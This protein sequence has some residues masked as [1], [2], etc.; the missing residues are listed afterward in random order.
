MLRN[1]YLRVIV[2]SALLVAALATAGA[3]HT[4]SN[5]DTLSATDLNSNFTHIH[6]SMVGG[7]GARL[8][9]A[10]VSTSANIAYTKLQNGRGIARAFGRVAGTCA[11]G[12][13]TMDNQLNLTSI[14]HTGT[15]VYT[16]TMNY[17]ATNSSFTALGNTENSTNICFA[18]PTST[19]TTVVNCMKR[20]D[21]SAN[22]GP[23]DVVI[24]DND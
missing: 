19:T 17:T 12:T 23:F 15:G 8:L 22:D 20:S 18:V 9:D 10:D 7:H 14:V 5:G 1:S 6:N 2:F 3:I 24:F 11:A 4:W 13:C 21:G 16:V